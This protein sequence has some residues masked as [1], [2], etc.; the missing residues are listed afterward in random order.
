M[1]TKDYVYYAQ[2]YCNR[3]HPCTLIKCFLTAVSLNIIRCA[4]GNV[5][6]SA[7]R[8]VKKMIMSQL[9]MCRKKKN[10][11]VLFQTCFF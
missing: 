5:Y 9:E 8:L 2:H 6:I 1:S 10:T 4:T 3:F 11:P 7:L